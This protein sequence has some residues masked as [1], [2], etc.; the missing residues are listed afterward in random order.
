MGVGV[1]E[2]EDGDAVFESEPDVLEAVV[3]VV[4]HQAIVVDWMIGWRSREVRC[5][6]SCCQAS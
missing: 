4:V 3:V 2:D 1:E 5:K 6:H